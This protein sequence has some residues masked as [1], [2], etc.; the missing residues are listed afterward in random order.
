MKKIILAMRPWSFVVSFISVAITSVG[1]CYLGY[2]INWW[3]AAWAALGVVLFH[4][5]ANTLSD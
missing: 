5:A 2:P 4:A 1:L 3:M